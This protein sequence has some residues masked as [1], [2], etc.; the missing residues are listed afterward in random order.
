MAFTQAD[1]DAIEKAMKQGVLRVR[2]GQSEVEYRSIDE[3]RAQ[4]DL[5][6]QELGLTGPGGIGVQFLGFRKGIR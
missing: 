2:D 6:R 4:R 3:M 5:I 1:L